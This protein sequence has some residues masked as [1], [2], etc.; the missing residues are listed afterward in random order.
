MFRQLTTEVFFSVHIGDTYAYTSWA[1]QF[2]EAL[3][4]GVIY[5]RWTH[6][7]FWGYGSPTFILYSPLSFYLISLYNVF[8]GSIILSMNIAQFTALFLCSIGMFFLIREFYP[9]RTALLTAI[10]YIFLPFNMSQMYVLGNFASNISIF[11]FPLVFLFIF[12]YLEKYNYRYI[13]YAGACYGGLILTHL[14]N[15]YMF[16]FVILAFLI[17][18]SIVR[19]RLKDLIALPFIILIGILIA[20]AYLFPLMYEKQFVHLEVFK[21]LKWLIFS[22]FFILPNKTGKLVNLA[23]SVYYNTYL[24]HTLFFLIVILLFFVQSVKLSRIKPLTILNTINKFFIGLSLVSIFLLFGP[25]TFLWESVPFFAYIQFPVRWLNIT[26]FA[27]AFLSASFFSVMNTLNS[28]KM[29][30]YFIPVVLFLICILLDYRYIS[31]PS[32]FTKQELIPIH[33]VNWTFEHLPARVDIKR[34]SK[35]N[36]REETVII[37]GAGKADVIKWGP[38]ERVVEI[39]ADQPV[40]VRLKIFNFPGWKAF[41]DGMQTEIKTEKDVGAMIIDI[42]EGK[43]KLELRFEDTPIRYYSKIVSLVS[44]LAMCCFLLFYKHKSQ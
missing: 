27:V 13:I 30:R 5:P 32:V 25:S 43:H 35:G 24:F 4:D 34:V 38:C 29:K 26:A 8:T 1:W 41:I 12:R 10:F 33:G 20:A 2:I 40:T 28:S 42:P 6:L 7:D 22:D 15:A 36:L 18:I 31:T 17:Y 11:W 3:K 44:F 14:I 9:E 16:T 23:W 19:K 39:A 37:R 21:T